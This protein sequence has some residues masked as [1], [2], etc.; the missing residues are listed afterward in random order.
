MGRPTFLEL[1]PV[2]NKWVSDNVIA[3]KC[4]VLIRDRWSLGFCQILISSMQV[5][6]PRLPWIRQGM[7]EC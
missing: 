6:T 3:K 5:L 2:V 1:M 7:G 4:V